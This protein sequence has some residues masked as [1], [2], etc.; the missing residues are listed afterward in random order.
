MMCEKGEH[1]STVLCDPVESKLLILG[2]KLISPL[3]E[4]HDNLYLNSYFWG[5]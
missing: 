1:E 4:N 5:L 3:I 2:D